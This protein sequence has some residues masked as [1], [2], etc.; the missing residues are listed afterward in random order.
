M[1]IV[2]II[3][4]RI[5][6]RDVVPHLLQTWLTKYKVRRRLLRPLLGATSVTRMAKTTPTLSLKMPVRYFPSGRFNIRKRDVSVEIHSVHYEEIPRQK[7]IFPIYLRLWNW[8]LL[9]HVTFKL[10][11]SCTEIGTLKI[12]QLINSKY[13]KETIKDE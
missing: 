10:H 11:R 2:H 13:K 8:Q 12:K 5:Y 3:L 7:V 6:K 9:R 1:C 4:V